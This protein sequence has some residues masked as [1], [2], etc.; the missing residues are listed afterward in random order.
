LPRTPPVPRPRSTT[1]ITETKANQEPT[2]KERSMTESDVI[3]AVPPR[4]RSNAMPAAIPRP[5]R[6]A[7]PENV[8]GIT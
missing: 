2:Q 1:T 3:L 6:P 5:T 8:R 4:P 7:I